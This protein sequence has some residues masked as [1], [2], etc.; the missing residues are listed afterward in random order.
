M[1]DFCIIGSAKCGTSALNAM[2]KKQA[3]FAMCPIKESHYFSTKAIH[4]KGDDW[5]RGLYHGAKPG[6]ILGEASTSYTRYPLVRG[7]AERMAAAN[8]DLKLIYIIRE[9]VKRTESECLQ[10]LKYAR[11]VLGEDNT[12]M[13]LDDYFDM[14][15]NPAHPHHTAIFATS[16]YIDQIDA[17]DACFPKENMLVLLQ[18]DLHNDSKKVLAQICDFL[19]ADSSKLVTADVTKNVTAEW[20]TSLDRENVAS[21]FRA[22]PFYDVLKGLL[23]ERI[24]EKL[25][26]AVPGDSKRL[27]FSEDR[28]ALLTDAFRAPNR[29]LRE[30][31]GPL[32]EDWST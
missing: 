8:P 5:Y 22:I 29:H 30:R 10:T 4:E 9:P 26:A 1:P 25:L 15:E 16:C 20:K 28:R 6:Q 31:I 32:P 19:G 13:T 11:N 3:D 21:K 17:F 2:L 27:E 18:N 23:P 12:H 14:I 7:T 24:K